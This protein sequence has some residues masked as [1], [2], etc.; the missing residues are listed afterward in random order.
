M[1]TA[2]GLALVAISCALMA[3]AVAAG[4]GC[5]AQGWDRAAWRCGLAAG[6]FSALAVLG[7]A[8]VAFGQSGAHG[9]GH[10][11]GHDVYKHWRAPDN[12][13]LSC[14]NN[15]DCRPTRAYMGDD[16]LW[17]A[18][19]GLSWLTVPAGRVLPTD[20]A[21]DGRSHLCERSGAVLCFTPGQPRG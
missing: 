5:A 17:R 12:E 4:R 7:A 11:Q 14:C 21:G 9:D 6:L 15:E 10:A 18:W 2:S 13:H 16:G 3:V 8:S 20:F 19:D 1:A